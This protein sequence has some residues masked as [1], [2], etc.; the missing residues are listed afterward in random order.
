MIGSW[1]APKASASRVTCSPSCPRS[2]LKKVSEGYRARV[3]I[4]FE[5]AGQHNEIG[6]AAER[7]GPAGSFPEATDTIR[8][9]P[10]YKAMRLRGSDISH[11]AKE[12]TCS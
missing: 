7:L 5:A 3:D 6:K 8:K 1:F 12:S 2:W 10:S 4:G 9:Y 11:I